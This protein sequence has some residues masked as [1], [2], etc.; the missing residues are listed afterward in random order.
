MA[1]HVG[2]LFNDIIYGGFDSN[3]IWGDYVKA[4]LA[5]GQVGGDD[6]IYGG[7]NADTIVGDAVALVEEARG[8]NDII[9]GDPIYNPSPAGSVL[10]PLPGVIAP[11]HPSAIPIGDISHMGDDI[12]FGDALQMLNSSAGGND[13]IY[14]KAGNDTIYGDAYAM[15][16]NSVGGRDW[17]VGGAGS[18][19]LYGDAYTMSGSALG[20]R[21]IIRGGDV[22][23]VDGG[24][25]NA[26]Y[27]D[28]F[29]M[30]GLARGGNDEMYGGDGND[31]MY[32]DAFQM[33]GSAAGGNDTLAG[34]AGDDYL[35]GDSCSA[36]ANVTGGNDWLNGGAGNDN[37]WGGRGAD[38]FQ[39]VDFSAS[40]GVVNSHTGADV[41]HDFSQAEG[42]KIDLSY[43]TGIHHFSDV[44]ITENGNQDA[45]IHWAQDSSVTVLGIHANQLHASD[46]ILF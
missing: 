40:N 5:G 43:I 30:T 24:S 38:V 15:F 4:P 9:Y 20:G 19:T 32:G 44:V 46:F 29:S 35:Y 45:V 8:G 36:T 11:S 7:P 22:F 21:D 2:T 13:Q 14:G 42:D 37:L 23:G 10:G 3:E 28:A 6:T 41:I 1:K 17:I 34:G 33:S 16:D 31:V 26:L 27:G 39:F 25:H 12:I 18:D